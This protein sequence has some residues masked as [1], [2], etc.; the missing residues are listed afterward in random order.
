M[1]SS[2][3]YLLI[4]AIVAVPEIVMVTEGEQFQICASVNE[5]KLERDVILS[6]DVVPTGAFSSNIL[7]Q[8]STQYYKVGRELPLA[9]FLMTV[10]E[11]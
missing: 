7:L 10:P 11:I 3:L 9:I 8:I 6:F 1:I 5:T 4:G 2:D